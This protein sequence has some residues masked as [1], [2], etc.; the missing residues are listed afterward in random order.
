MDERLL[1]GSVPE[2]GDERADEQ[3]LREAHSGVGGH[4][5]TAQLDEPEASGAAV[6]RV[7]FVDADFGAMRVSGDVDE[8]VPEKSVDD[9]WG[10]GGA[11]G[12]LSKGDVQ[13]VEGIFPAFI[14]ARGLAGWPDEHA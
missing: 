13:F 3:L 11:V 7:E 14:D 8:Q 12:Q 2:P 5:E 1:V 9:P 10:N 4:F 6:G